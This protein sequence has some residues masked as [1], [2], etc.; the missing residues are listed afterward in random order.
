M[1][2]TYF[3]NVNTMSE[4]KETY[5]NLAKANH[6]DL[7]GSLEAMQAINAQYETLSEIFAASDK[8]REQEEEAAE[9]FKDIINKFVGALDLTIEVCGTWIWFSGNTKEYKEQLKEMGCMWASKKMMWYWRPSEE[10]RKGNRKTADM[11][12]IRE[13]YGS[14]VVTG[15]YKA[16]YLQ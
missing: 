3:E 6:P 7:G 10:S 1:T 12:S 5:R 16:S 2:N 8:I 9:K 11:S 4:L 14:T 15:S 13:K